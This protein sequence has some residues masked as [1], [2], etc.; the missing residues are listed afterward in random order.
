MSQLKIKAIRAKYEA[1]KATAI[2]ELDF[3]MNTPSTGEFM[4]AIEENLKKL[5]NAN[6]MLNIIDAA[7]TVSSSESNESTQ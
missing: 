4:L 7:F 2:A 6:Q 5:S 3:W 1:E